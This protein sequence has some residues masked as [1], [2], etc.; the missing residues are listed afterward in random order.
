M[1]YL[2]T[3]WDDGHPLDLRVAELLT[4][5]GLKGTFYVPCR[6]REGKPVLSAEELR[7]LGGNFEIGSHSLDHCV[8]DTVEPVEAQRQI[9]QGKQRLE[10]L[11]GRRVSGFAYPGGRFRRRYTAMLRDAGFS[12][13]RTNENFFSDVT[14]DPYRLPTT[15]QFY[16]H[17]NEVFV[18]NFISKGNWNARMRLFAIAIQ[19]RDMLE[20]F[21]LMLDYVCDNERVFHLWGH[22]W[23]LDQFDGWR[24]LD[25]FL[26]YAAERVPAER[27]VDNGGLVMRLFSAGIR[28]PAGYAARVH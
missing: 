19:S 16:P 2:I 21:R 6:N 22:S 25:A 27:R 7:A 11:Y 5:H 1:A 15:L 13:A 4:K 20:R 24:L 26:R 28:Q 12:Y 9:V 3:S 23:E 17:T 8:L 10:Y 14:P 18:R